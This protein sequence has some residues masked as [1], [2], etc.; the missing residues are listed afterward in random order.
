ME[1]IVNRNMVLPDMNGTLTEAR[2]PFASLLSSPIR[3]L[4]QIADIGIT[5]AS[6]LDY[7]QGQSLVITQNQSIQ[8]CLPVLCLR[9]KQ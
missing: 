3:S 7:V 8:H 5:T 2:R 6:D 1:I 4:G 9:G